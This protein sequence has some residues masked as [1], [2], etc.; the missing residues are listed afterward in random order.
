MSLSLSS[1]SAR[2]VSTRGGGGGGRHKRSAS[3]RFDYDDASLN[4]YCDDI[5]DYYTSVMGRLLHD[6]FNT[7]ENSRPRSEWKAI[8]DSCVNDNV[9]S[10]QG[11]DFRLHVPFSCLISGKSQC[12]PEIANNIGLICTVGSGQR[13]RGRQNVTRKRGHRRTRHSRLR[14]YRRRARR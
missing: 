10:L 9:Q 7:C 11:V 13:R 3:D 14:R 6:D 5:T 1:S 8:H 4:K 2:S 12:G